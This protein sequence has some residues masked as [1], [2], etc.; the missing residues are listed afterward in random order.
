MPTSTKT[1]ATAIIT[2][3][4]TRNISPILDMKIDE[5]TA[6]LSSYYVK[7]LRSVDAMNG[8]TIVDYMA[9]MRIEVNLSDH[10]RKNVIE[11]ICRFSNYNK[12]KPFKDI[13]RTDIITFL[14]TYRKT[15]TQD[16]LLLLLRVIL[17]SLCLRLSLL[18]NQFVEFTINQVT[19]EFRSL[20]VPIYIL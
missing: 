14:D 19:N 4:R 6:G 3:A 17:R 12:G 18:P 15:D 11:L 16:P 5:T 8:V 1:K 2:A 9:A 10:Y 13:T 7:Y 20:R